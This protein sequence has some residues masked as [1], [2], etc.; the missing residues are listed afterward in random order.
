MASRDRTVN[1]GC[2]LAAAVILLLAGA[3]LLLGA[4]ACA[5]DAEFMPQDSVIGQFILLRGAVLG[6]VAVAALT[7]GMLLLALTSGLDAMRGLWLD[8]LDL[9][10]RVY[11]LQQRLHAKVGGDE[12]TP[13]DPVRVHAPAHVQQRKPKQPPPLPAETTRDAGGQHARAKDGRSRTR[14]S[15]R[16]AGGIGRW[17]R[18]PRS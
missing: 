18:R 8:A 16:V 11:W 5:M 2:V 1:S 4:L 17:L 3:G 15:G 7:G 14:S 10:R 9:R 6:G 12:P 13:I